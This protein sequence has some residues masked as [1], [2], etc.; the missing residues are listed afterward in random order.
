[1][2]RS[3]DEAITNQQIIQLFDGNHVTLFDLRQ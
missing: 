2:A 3:I 1:L